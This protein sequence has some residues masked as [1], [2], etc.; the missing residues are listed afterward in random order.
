MSGSYNSAPPS[1]QYHIHDLSR[2]RHTLYFNTASLIATSLVHSRLNS[3]YSLLQ[4]QLRCLQCIEKSLAWIIA[5]IPLHSPISSTRKSLHCLKVEQR[6]QYTIIS[7]IHNILHMPSYL[8][9]LITPQPSG[10][11][12]SS[13]FH[14][15]PHLQAKDHSFLNASPMLWNSLP[16]LTSYVSTPSL[17]SIFLFPSCS[18]SQPIPLLP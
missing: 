3:L 14:S 16:S 12:C 10:H 8:C 9:T 17:T 5:H 15:T 2:I 6:M 13:S 7:I 11:P 1:S 18:I 4:T